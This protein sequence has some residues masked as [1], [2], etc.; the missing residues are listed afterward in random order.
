VG[1]LL[2]ALAVSAG[3]DA[4]DPVAAVQQVP[5]SRLAK[6]Y[7]GEPFASWLREQ[8]GEEAATFLSWSTN[9]CGE[10][11]MLCVEA[12]VPAEDG[13]LVRFNVL[14]GE[15]GPELWMLYAIKKEGYRTIESR[16]FSTLGAALSYLRGGDEAVLIHV[17]GQADGEL[18]P[19]AGPPPGDYVYQECWFS[20]SMGPAS[21]RTHLAP[22][23][24]AEGADRFSA[25][26]EIDTEAR[27]PAPTGEAPLRYAG[28]ELAAVFAEHPTLEGPWYFSS[29]GRRTV[30]VSV[31]SATFLTLPINGERKLTLE[32]GLEPGHLSGAAVGVVASPRIPD[33]R[34][35]TIRETSTPALLRA[36][37]AALG[38]HAPAGADLRRVLTIGPH[39]VVP[40]WSSAPLSTDG[41]WIDGYGRPRRV[42]DVPGVWRHDD[43]NF[44]TYVRAFARGVTGRTVLVHQR[45]GRYAAYDTVF[46][47]SERGLRRCGRRTLG[48]D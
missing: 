34:E 4:A 20:F 21:D 33:Y 2:L 18:R 42:A 39:L 14:L 37:T 17:L 10:S 29:H 38:R 28:K 7:P 9:D 30:Q 19:L 41:L 8:V 44:A 46:W 3:A 13:F 43:G 31:L 35:W 24:V 32:F 6:G 25:W 40:V 16:V 23:S 26:W 45:E 48:S 15:S 12:S 1:A 27:L 11:E 22:V 36:V 47:L 5:V